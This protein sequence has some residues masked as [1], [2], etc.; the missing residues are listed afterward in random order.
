CGFDDPGYLADDLLHAPEATPG[1]DGRFAHRSFD[2]TRLHERFEI[3]AISGL[4]H[5]FQWN[6]LQRRRIDAVTQTTLVARA[7]IKHM[8]EMRVRH[9]RAHFRPHH[10]ESRVL[11]LDNV[12]AFHRLG[13]RSEEHTSELQS[14][15]YLVCR[16]LL[17][18]KM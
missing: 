13:E 9:F 15:A 3:P 16:L 14:L 4:V 2:Q 11:L 18:K 12:R 10:A 7:V 8:T 5:F 1:Q 17:E 6:E